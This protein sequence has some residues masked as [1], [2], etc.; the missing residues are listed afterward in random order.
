[1]RYQQLREK[2]T[3]GR[4]VFAKRDK[5]ARHQFPRRPVRPGARRKEMHH[6]LLSL[7]YTD[8]ARTTGPTGG[9]SVYPNGRF[10]GIRG[11]AIR[12]RF[13]FF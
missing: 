4:Y 3:R 5:N 6:A 12:D 8:L 2:Q 13:I 9:R 1:M 10:S 11:G 7:Q